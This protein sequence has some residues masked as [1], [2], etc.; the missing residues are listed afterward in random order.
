MDSVFGALLLAPFAV[1]CLILDAAAVRCKIVQVKVLP[2]RLEKGEI[3]RSLGCVC[4]CLWG[5]GC[6]CRE[7]LLTPCTSA[8]HHT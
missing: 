8:K 6:A 5:R 7:P 1:R 3:T 4:V 2:T